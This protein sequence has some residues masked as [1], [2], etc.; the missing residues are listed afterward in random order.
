LVEEILKMKDFSHPNVLT[1]MGVALDLNSTPCLVMPFM[2]NGSLSE[3]LRREDVRKELLWDIEESDTEKTVSKSQHHA[4][5][6][7]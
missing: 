6:H 5:M 7:P 4:S 2:S 3:Y 1:L